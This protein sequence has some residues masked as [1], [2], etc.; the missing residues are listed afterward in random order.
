MRT[1]FDTIVRYIESC[2]LIQQIKPCKR[3]LINYKAMY[4][5]NDK[6]G[7]VVI[8]SDILR[9]KELELTEIFTL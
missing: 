3:L 7:S 2:T 1:A 5:L 6:D 8:L 4:Q 9:E